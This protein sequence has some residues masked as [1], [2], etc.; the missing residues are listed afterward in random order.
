MVVVGE[1]E[2]IPVGTS[3]DLTLTL[4]PGAYA[5]ICNVVDPDTNEAHHQMGMRTG[6]TVSD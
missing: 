6:F 2:D 3:P 1:I 5:L 4:E